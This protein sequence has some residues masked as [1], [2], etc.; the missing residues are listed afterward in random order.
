MSIEL[1]FKSTTKQVAKTTPAEHG[2]TSKAMSFDQALDVIECYD[3]I[4]KEAVALRD[5]KNTRADLT[6]EGF[7][8]D[9]SNGLAKLSFLGTAVTGVGVLTTVFSS[10]SPAMAMLAFLTFI[11]LV[12]G[13]AMADRVSGNPEKWG[14]VFAKK[15]YEKYQEDKAI[16]ESFT[17]LAQ[18]EFA[19][20]E[21]VVLKKSRKAVKLVNQHLKP[22][23]QKIVY[24]SNPD[25][26]GFRIQSETPVVLSQWDK[27][28]LTTN[29][30]ES[31]TALT[32]AVHNK[33]LTS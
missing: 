30:Y 14:K 28:R 10:G 8:R 17:L 16:E 32:G 25:A 26:T 15:K 23:N 7:A 2:S 33:A 1:S 20:K 9:A 11:P 31:T 18:E 29:R 3:G 21:K 12:G 22:Q 27:L 19:S 6:L 5:S 13:A 4:I 24:D